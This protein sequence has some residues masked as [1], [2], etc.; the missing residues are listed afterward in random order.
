MNGKSI[1]G[2]AVAALLAFPVLAEVTGEYVFE[3]SPIKD[4]S[5]SGHEPKTQPRKEAFVKEDGIS[6]IRMEKGDGVRLPFDAFPGNSGQMDCELKVESVSEPRHLLIVYGKGDV[7][8]FLVRRGAVEVRY[9]H[10]GGDG[11]WVTGKR[12]PLPTDKSVKLSISWTLPGKI[13]VSVDG[14][15]KGETAVAEAGGFDPGSVVF[16]GSN[17]RNEL[18]FPGVIRSVKFSYKD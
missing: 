1:L 16:I 5:G 18:V 2:A 14:E 9:M 7:M 11:K 3:T 15:A 6:G 12:I 8:A 4:S 17:Q 10:R 13:A